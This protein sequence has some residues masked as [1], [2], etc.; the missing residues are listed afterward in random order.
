MA[1]RLFTSD[2]NSKANLQKIQAQKDS[3]EDETGEEYIASDSGVFRDDFRRKRLKLHNQDAHPRITPDSSSHPQVFLNLVIFINGY[4]QPSISK[5]HQLIVKHGGAFL[6]YMDGKMTVTHIIASALTPKKRAEFENYKVVKP[7]WIVESVSAGKLL[8]WIDFKTLEA[9]TRTRNF[10]GHESAAALTSHTIPR[11]DE[12]E[13][14]EELG[15]DL[16]PSYQVP[17]KNVKTSNNEDIPSSPEYVIKE[18]REDGSSSRRKPPRISSSHDSQYIGA[19]EEV[20]EPP[21]QPDED[22]DEYFEEPSP[23]QVLLSSPENKRRMAPEEDDA[24]DDEY[25]LT[26]KLKKSKPMTA[27][28]YNMEL[29]SDPKVREASVLNPDF[30]KKYNE[31]SRL[32]HLSTWKS[33]LQIKV[34][35]LVEQSS[36]Q[37]PAARSRPRRYILHVDLDCFFAS[38]ALLSRPDLVLKPVV[39]CHSSSPSSEIASCNYVARGF[40]VKNGMWF[41]RA[42]A[43]CPDLN[44]LGY[45]FVGYERASEGFYSVIVGLGGERVQAV[46]VD[47][48]L[49]DIS[50]LCITTADGDEDSEWQRAEE[51]AQRVRRDVNAKIKCDVSVGIGSNVLLARLA[52][53]K[54][55]PA[56]Q[57]TVRT[58]DM[59]DFLNEIDINALPGIGG[60]I[61][62]KIMETFGTNKCGKIREAA[63]REHLMRV[64]GEKTGIKIWSYVRGIDAAQVGEAK[65]GGAGRKSVSV[66]VNWGVRF[67]NQE[68]AETF[69]HSLAGEAIRRLK[70]QKLL[71]RQLSLKINKR[72]ADV[73]FKTEK[74]LGRGCCDTVHRS[75]ALGM[76]TDNVEVVAHQ[77]LLLLREARISPGELR[78]LNISLGG[79]EDVGVSKGAQKKLDFGKAVAM[80]EI[81]T[82]E[83][84]KPAV[85]KV[86]KAHVSPK[87]NTLLSYFPKGP[88]AIERKQGTKRDEQKILPE[89]L[90]KE[91]SPKPQLLPPPDSGYNIEIWNELGED[92]KRSLIA[93]HEEQRRPEEHR[94]REN[95]SS[96]SSSK[97]RQPSSHSLR[98]PRE[99]PA[100]KAP[101]LN[102][103]P[104]FDKDGNDITWIFTDGGIDKDWFEAVDADSRKW[105]IT[106]AN[107][108]RAALIRERE[109]RRK[110]AKQE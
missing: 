25:F 76:A 35:T 59:Q 66:D 104:V 39:V 48:A 30:M 32:H 85:Q 74:F 6:Q 12:I 5:L 91:S 18:R 95:A 73:P 64:L 9:G 52:M 1:N 3:F 43:L 96:S 75:A 15:F 100:E 71:A 51:I 80:E 10:W 4:T 92:I 107:K 70:L 16:I 63:A 2:K 86:V 60:S 103:V 90:E 27:E 62:G 83:E 44:Q 67:E 93:E 55:K 106:E 31:S 47:E 21:P 7:E 24:D 11:S 99:S 56:G 29:L 58:K 23:E 61:A 57:F 54:A 82:R 98:N 108:T 41:S 8:P 88:S 97:Q 68:Q 33:E 36:S 65:D 72:A 22:N 37:K 77:A 109:R 79:L 26:P 13:A 34:A 110:E 14:E 53:R 40:G 89:P 101:R 50:N 87:L 28:E 20:E 102:T 42:K 78:G 38:I 46:S 17:I 105:A 81:Q 69:I 45:D 84:V 49:V 19:Q 94:Q